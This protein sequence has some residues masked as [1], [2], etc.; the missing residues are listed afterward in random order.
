MNGNILT[1]GEQAIFSKRLYE[2]EDWPV[3]RAAASAQKQV[4]KT[5]IILTK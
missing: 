4:S 5:P 1:F 2:A 3:F